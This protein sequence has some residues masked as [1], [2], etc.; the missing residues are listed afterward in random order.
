MH[1]A[2]LIMILLFLTTG[3]S[4]TLNIDKSIQKLDQQMITPDGTQKQARSAEGGSQTYSIHIN[5]WGDED[6]TDYQD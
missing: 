2:A 6:Y 5:P 1:K 3:C 4:V